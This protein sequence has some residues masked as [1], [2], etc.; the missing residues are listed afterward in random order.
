MGVRTELERFLKLKEASVARMNT[1]NMWRPD[2][3]KLKYILE[4]RNR[5]LALVT[6]VG[7]IALL[8]ARHA[9]GL[10]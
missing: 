2:Q 8:E 5:R 7:I 9:I 4:V 1:G 3:L 6:G 10:W